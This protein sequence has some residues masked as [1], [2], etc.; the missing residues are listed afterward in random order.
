M[1]TSELSASWDALK[2]VIYKAWDAGFEEG[3]DEA[4]LLADMKDHLAAKNGGERMDAT[5][6]MLWTEWKAKQ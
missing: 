3:L 4:F 5:V 1:G 6:D 2:E